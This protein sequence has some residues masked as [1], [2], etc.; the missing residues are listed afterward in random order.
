MNLESLFVKFSSYILKML[1][2]KFVNQLD[3]S[4]GINPLF[5]LLPAFFDSKGRKGLFYPMVVTIR[6]RQDA[7]RLLLL[8]GGTVLEPALKFM[9]I[10]AKKVKSNHQK[11]NNM[12]RFFWQGKE[13]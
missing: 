7:S 4:L 10:R 6:A 2:N 1:F 8:E 12:L 9:A 13:K 5:H 11:M 3:G